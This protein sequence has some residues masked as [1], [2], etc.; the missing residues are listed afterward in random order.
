MCPMRRREQACGCRQVANVCRMDDALKVPCQRCQKLILPMTA[1]RTGGF[2]MTCFG[3]P[4]LRAVD[5]EL[6][7]GIGYWPSAADPDASK[8]PDPKTLVRH[9]WLP[10][11]SRARLLRYLRSAS[12]FQGSWGHS[13]CRFECG[14]NCRVMG[15]REYWDGA[16]V[17]PEGLAHYVECH[18]VCLPDE[19]VQRALASPA[20]D[21]SGA[22]E[23]PGLEVDWSYWLAWSAQLGAK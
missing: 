10:S 18:D 1:S 20:D 14:V 9:D 3:R 19:F 21:S 8:F 16:W 15:S 12:L 23:C 17:W 6:P 13:F 5:S 11:E 7:R 4:P 2:C 22:P